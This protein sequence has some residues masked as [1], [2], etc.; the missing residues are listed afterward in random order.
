MNEEMPDVVEQSEEPGVAGTINEIDPEKLK[1]IEKRLKEFRDSQARTESGSELPDGPQFDL[2]DYEVDPQLEHLYRRARVENTAEGP[3]WVILEH[4]YMI[5]TGQWHIENSGQPRGK[6]KHGRTLYH[7]RGLDHL[8][9]EIVNGA[10]GMYST[11]KGWRLS[12]LLPGP[13][14]QGIAVFERQVKRALPDPKPIVKPEEEPLEE[15]TDEELARMDERAKNW[16][17]ENAGGN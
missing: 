9:N 3:K 1:L 12:A 16:T 6:D 17:E 10:E 8:I 2:A 7:A 4:Q 13:M 5:Q 14:G 15:T 11:E